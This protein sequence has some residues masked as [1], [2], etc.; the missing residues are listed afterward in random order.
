MLITDQ[1]LYFYVPNCRRLLEGIFRHVLYGKEEE[2]G[3]KGVIGPDRS[4]TVEP[5]TPVPEGSIS[6]SY[7]SQTQELC[8]VMVPVTGCCLFFM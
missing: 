8:S 1:S 2:G 6:V 5:G 3:R 4:T 7:L